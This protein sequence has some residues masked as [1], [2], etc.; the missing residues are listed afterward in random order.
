MNDRG[1]LPYVCWKCSA[2]KSIDFFTPSRIATDG[3]TMMNFDQPYRLCSS[4]IVL[5]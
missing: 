2:V 3:T 4:I 5:M 1:L